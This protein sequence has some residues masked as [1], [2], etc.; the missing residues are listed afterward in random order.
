VAGSLLIVDWPALGGPLLHA[1]DYLLTGLWRIM[2]WLAVLPSAQV[3]FAAAP[4]WALLLGLTGMAWMLLPRGVPARALGV[5][6]L[7]PLLMPPQQDLVDGEFEAWMFDVGQG[8]AVLV[9]SRD[10][11]WLYDAGPRYPSGFDVGEAVVIPSLRALGIGALERIVISHGD[12]DHA[13]GAPALHLAFPDAPIE[14]GEPHRLD[15]PADACPGA[16][17]DRTDGVQLRALAAPRSGTI[18]SNDRSCVILVSGRYGSLL[19][20]GD[21]TS[22][23][24]PAIA[25][26]LGEVPRPLVMS[27]PHH[28]SKTAS[29]A[30]FLEAL[31]PQLGLISAGYKNQFGHPHA[32]VLD[33]YARL[34]VPLMNTAGSGYLHVRFVRDGLQTEQ[35]RLLRSAWWRVQ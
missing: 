13:G 10:G 25:A 23:A 18:K 19:L 31:S 14:S 5:L 12:S 29:S 1:A 34:A 30:A 20:T 11:A 3:Y 32:D 26:A 35:G 27:V 22:K 16:F 15:L 6:L 28:G 4:L 9:R 21:A 2:E 8:L 33:R 24:E 7:L 17:G